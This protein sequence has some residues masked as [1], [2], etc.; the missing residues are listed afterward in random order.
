LTHQHLQMLRMRQLRRERRLAE[1]AAAPVTTDTP[2]CSPLVEAT[3]TTPLSPPGPLAS[4][5]PSSTMTREPWRP[6]P[7]HPWRH[8]PIGKAKY[9]QRS[10][11]WSARN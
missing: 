3:A 10:R 4:V 5:L 2:P 8:S 11:T 6:G 1:H 7:D 9:R